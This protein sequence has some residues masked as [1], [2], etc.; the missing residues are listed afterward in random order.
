MNILFV[1][2]W[3]LLVTENK[4]V[5]IIGYNFNPVFY[6]SQDHPNDCVK[7][8]CSLHLRI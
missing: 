2:I 3:L 4:I 8:M 6:F 5:I 7:N 1:C